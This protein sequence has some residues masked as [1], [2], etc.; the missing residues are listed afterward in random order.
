MNIYLIETY[1]KYYNKHDEYENIYKRKFDTLLEEIENQLSVLNLKELVDLYLKYS[2]VNYLKNNYM[3]SL[4]NLIIQNIKVKLPHTQSIEIMDIYASLFDSMLSLEDNIQSYKNI[5]KVRSYNLT[6][7]FF[8]RNKSSKNINPSFLENYKK[9]LE[10]FQEFHDLSISS[11]NYLDKVQV[12]IMD[13]L[14]SKINELTSLEKENLIRDVN[15][16]IE[17]CF[18]KLNFQQN[19]LK[20]SKAL[21]IEIRLN[22]LNSYNILENFN[23][24]SIRN[25]LTVYESYQS[26]LLEDRKKTGK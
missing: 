25:K 15:K 5:I 17:L 9:E 12:I 19:L 1:I 26:K 7:E 11:F 23:S 8:L 3:N 21:E 13:T 24:Q 4:L 10:G 16:R 22:G 6:D 20:N 18:H 14:E 2:A